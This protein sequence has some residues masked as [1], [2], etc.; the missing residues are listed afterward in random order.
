MERAINKTKLS[1][2]KSRREIK[3]ASRLLFFSSFGSCEQEYL[4]TESSL[5]KMKRVAK[6]SEPPVVV[7]VVVVLVDVH[8]ALVIPPVERGEYCAG[9]LP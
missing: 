7:P 3:A 1:H 9:Y 2:L 5:A 8:V 6:P 4:F